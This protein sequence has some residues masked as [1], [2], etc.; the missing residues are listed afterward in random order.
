MLF[1]RK[2]KEKEENEKLAK[3]LDNLV[4]DEYLLKDL[5]DLDEKEKK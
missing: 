3:D 2:R 5:A 4:E 1:S